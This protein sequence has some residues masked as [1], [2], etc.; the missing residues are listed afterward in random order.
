MNIQGWR[1]F[2]FALRDITGSSIVQ[3]YVIYRR[4]FVGSALSNDS[5]RLKQLKRES[6][7]IGDLKAALRHY[8]KIF[9]MSIDT[10]APVEILI[11]LI[12]SLL[13]HFRR[14][15]VAPRTLSTVVPI[16]AAITTIIIDERLINC[17]K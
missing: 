3:C 5:S 14:S 4:D 2:R 11:K 12:T 6:T 8:Y 10:P 9:T 7:E 13:T 1:E 15:M 17:N 16:K